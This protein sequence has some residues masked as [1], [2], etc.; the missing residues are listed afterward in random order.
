MLQVVVNGDAAFG[1]AAVAG[2][3]AF[4]W[5]VASEAGAGLYL[6][7][8]IEQYLVSRNGVFVV[9]AEFLC[10]VLHGFFA[11]GMRVVV[12]SR[13]LCGAGTAA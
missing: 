4:E 13:I 8:V 10:P 3:V 11:F 9:D 2:A 7:K 12:M 5:F 6:F 1:A